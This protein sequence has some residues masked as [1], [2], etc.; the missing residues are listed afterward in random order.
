MSRKIL[1]IITGDPRQDPRPAEAIRIAAGVSTWNKVEVSVYLHGNAAL[2][3]ADSADE[4]VDADNYTRYLPVL[5]EQNRR[6]YI[7][8]G[9]PWL[10]GLT[11]PT[12]S[13]ETLDESGL[14]ELAAGCDY[15][16]RF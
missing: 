10:A 7:R 4:F 1:F 5:G 11:E 13:Y 2:A 12:L 8:A 14:A 15:V 16:I 3:L 6:I 9:N